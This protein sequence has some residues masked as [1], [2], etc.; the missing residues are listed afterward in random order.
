MRLSSEDL[1]VW[2]LALSQ[3]PQLSSG[4]VYQ[5]PLESQP[6]PCEDDARQL[7]SWWHRTCA[8][9]IDVL[10]VLPDR[11]QIIEIKPRGGLSAVGQVLGYCW[12]YAE[13]ERPTVPVEPWVVC[14]QFD[15]S[16]LPFARLHGINVL[17]VGWPSH[18]DAGLFPPTL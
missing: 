9:R 3:Q 16:L 8:K 10:R 17:E 15:T 1:N 6:S 13:K 14:H 5:F 4:S 12:L 18:E 2:L 11:V 7:P